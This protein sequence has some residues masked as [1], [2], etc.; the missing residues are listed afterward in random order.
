M[1]D[2]GRGWSA[3]GDAAGP[4]GMRGARLPPAGRAGNGAPGPAGTRPG[5]AGLQ[6]DRRGGE[7]SDGEGKGSEPAKCV[8]D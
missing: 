8:L 7:R 3:A 6:W 5:R 2:A 4:G 1:K